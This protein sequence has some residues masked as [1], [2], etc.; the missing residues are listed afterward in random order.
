MASKH[1]RLLRSIFRLR[2][3]SAHAYKSISRQRFFFGQKNHKSHFYC[4]KHLIAE[5]RCLSIETLNFEM[6][7]TEHCADFFFYKIKQKL[8]TSVNS[9]EIIAVDCIDIWEMFANFGSSYHTGM[10]A[11]CEF[12]M[13][14]PSHR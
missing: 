8:V 5:N 11:P 6:E 13:S 10:R 14:F 9:L 7:E 4:C 12:E 1:V 3:L 2:V